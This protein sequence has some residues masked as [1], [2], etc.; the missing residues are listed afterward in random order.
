M[1]LLAR[2]RSRSS[3]WLVRVACVFGLVALA[4]MAYSILNPR[5]LPV[6]FAMSGGHVVG[7]LAFVAY[8]TA[9]LLDVNRSA[10][11][12]ASERTSTASSPGDAPPPARE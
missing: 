12:P 1:T 2:L 5:P 6:I 4:I 11:E 3:A 7:A 9:V 8:F 10:R